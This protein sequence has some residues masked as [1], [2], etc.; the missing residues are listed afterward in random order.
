[1]RPVAGWI[2]HLVALIQSCQPSHRPGRGESARRVAAP[3]RALPLVVVRAATA[4]DA[5]RCAEIFLAGRRQAFPD[6][7]LAIFGFDDYFGCVADQ[8]VWV[9]EVAGEIAGFVSASR[10]DGIIRNLFVAD[11]WQRR[12][13]G[14]LL[15]E[16]ASCR[17]NGAAR[18]HCSVRN[19]PACNF[20]Q[21][22]GWTQAG[23]G[24]GEGGEY[25]EFRK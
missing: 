22:I 15:L 5:P 20:Y 7:P 19:Q 14:R 16:H 10:D 12:G 25:I 23:I 13:I 17:L 9:A 1:M 6:P 24:A 8:E 4:A 2:A 3:E 18:L 21:H 11:S